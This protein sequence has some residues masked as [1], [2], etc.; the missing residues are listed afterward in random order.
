MYIVLLSNVNLKLLFQKEIQA[1]KLK[2]HEHVEFSS[3]FATEESNHPAILRLCSDGKFG[4][5]L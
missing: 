5:I 3:S 2:Q 1:L 4:F